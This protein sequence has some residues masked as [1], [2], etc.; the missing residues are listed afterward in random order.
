MAALYLRNHTACSR[1]ALAEEL[2]LLLLGLGIRYHPRTVKRQLT[3]TV[4]SV[5]PE[6]EAAMEQ[7][8]S[9]RN[10]LRNRSEVDHA[11]AAAGLQVDRPP[12]TQVAVDRI[13]P[14]GRL[15]LYLSRPESKRSLAVRLR[16]ALARRGTHYTVDS[17]QEILSGHRHRLTRHAVLEVLLALLAWHG[18]AS[19]AEARSCLQALRREIDAFLQGREVVGSSRFRRLCG[20][21]LLRHREPSA[22]RLAMLLQE[23]LRARGVILSLPT[24]QALASGRTPGV[25]RVVLKAMEDLVREELG[26]GL[27]IHE[28]AARVSAGLTDLGWVDARLIVARG[29]EWL[30][31]H[32]G[33]TRRQLALRLADIVRRMG[34]TMSHSSIQPLL[35]GWK[36]RG[37]VFVYRAVRMLAGAQP[38][39]N[40]DGGSGKCMTR[41]CIFPALW[42]GLCRHCWLSKHDSRPF[43]RASENARPL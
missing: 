40:A 43:D 2:R 14:L 9:E 1:G 36:R 21:W 33:A 24:V 30:A 32:P 22:R 7:L 23:R 28:E 3:G 12:S 42:E 10:G 6:V 38:C 39:A 16:D 26:P 20:L 27:D 37:R 18:I 19:E 41:S 35:G 31:R 25:R 15:W 13:V 5:P 17:L 11:L 4:L 8:L 34:Y 29:D